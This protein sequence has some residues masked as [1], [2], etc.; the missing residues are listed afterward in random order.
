MPR[1]IAVCPAL[2][3]C[4]VAS[5]PAQEAPPVACDFA[6]DIYDAPGFRKDGGDFL[7]L[8]ECLD[9]SGGGAVGWEAERSD[10]SL[11]DPGGGVRADEDGTKFAA[12]YRMLAY[13]CV[14][15]Q[16]ADVSLWARVRQPDKPNCLYAGGH[17]WSSEREYTDA[18]L[19]PQAE[20][21]KWAGQWRWARLRGMRLLQGM[22][23]IRLVYS[24][25][26]SPEID[27]L[28]VTPDGTTPE[29]PGP[30]ER[31]AAPSG[32]RLESQDV[33]LP[34]L[35]RL[36]S[37]EVLGDLR[38][39]ALEASIDEGQ[40]WQPARD[41][42]TPGRLRLRLTFPRGA[43][44]LG[45]ASGFC[46]QALVDPSQYLMLQSSG[47]RLGLDTTT[48]GVFRLTKTGSGTVS[49]G[50]G[51]ETVPD[52]VFVA[53][54]A[55]EPLFALELKQRGKPWPD[56]RYWLYPKD[57]RLVSAR[58]LSD[59]QA[60]IACSFLDG[61]LVATATVSV[62][63]GDE[64][65]WSLRI[66]NASEWD[67]LTFSFP[68]LAGLKIGDSGY[69]DRWLNTNR[70]G[71]WMAGFPP[72]DRPYP[73]WGALGF[74]DL[75]DESA[76]LSFATREP[77]DG[78]TNFLLRSMERLSGETCRLE[79]Q[80]EHCV[81]AGETRTWTY[82]VRL[83]AGDWHAAADAYGDWFRREFGEADFPD[84]A[85]DSNGWVQ[86]SCAL[87]DASYQWPQLLGLYETGRRMGITH[88][89]VWGQFGSNTCAS[90]WWPSP[91][92]GSAEEF[93]DANRRIREQGGH[94]GYY[95]LY[96]RENRYNVIDTAT[97]DGYLPRR[98]YP[99]DMP[100]VTPEALIQGAMVSD[101][102]GKVT[103]WPA[104]DAEMSAF[105]A[106][107]AKL[108]AEGKMTTWADTE[109]WPRHSMAVM[110]PQ[111]EGWQRWLEL[112]AIDYYVKRWHC[113]TAYEDVL[114]CGNPGRSFDLRRGDHGQV[115]NTEMALAQRL[116]E[117]GRRADPDFTLIAEGKQELVTRWAMGMASSQHYGWIDHA[118]HRYTHPD[119]ILFL[120]GSN[121]GYQQMYAN[122][123]RAY[124]FG[125]RFDLILTGD[126]YDIR[127]IVTFREGLKR[128]FTRAR[129]RDTVGLRVE[130]EG[131]EATRHDRLDAG[132]QSI[133]ATVVNRSGATDGVLAIDPTALGSATYGA[134]WLQDDW[135]V[136]PAALTSRQGWVSTTIPP[137]PASALLLVARAPEGEDLLG[138]LLPER[139]PNGWRARVWLANLTPS[140]RTVQ[141]TLQGPGLPTAP[142][143]VALPGNGVRNRFVEMDEGSRTETV[144]DPVF[145]DVTLLAEGKPLARNFLYPLLE[146]GSFEQDGTPLADAPDGE[147]A[148]H[149]GPAEGWQ[150]TY[151]LLNLVPG[152]RYQ[153]GVT[154]RRTGTQG[155]MYGLVRMRDGEQWHYASLNFPEQ[156]LN[157][158]VDLT[159]DFEA[160]PT[161]R[162]ANLY[163]YNSKSEATV[164]YDRLWV[165]MVE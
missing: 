164:D 25:P 135:T 59:S 23:T 75:Y 21:A 105:K 1:P 99:P 98:L 27:R 73:G 38:G 68:R 127:R 24:W 151:R 155:E 81:A 43:T 117:A 33:T 60:E 133:L 80:K 139:T 163:L 71:P 152:R 53:P 34:A 72:E 154:A 61:K 20:H 123:E 67:V 107:L 146:D 157:E 41:L 110:N 58:K 102:E 148:V 50:G 103:A 113:D 160:P 124:L 104:T 121:G 131:I 144:P 29:G 86:T 64:G 74:V 118:A 92:Y 79:A 100:Q 97:V 85:R 116:A 14:S 45:R 52:P 93:A 132:A 88:A 28:A 119:H 56:P 87:S 36:V 30:G 153:A 19:D 158:W 17:Q 57:G 156:P 42:D 46:V 89:Q 84:W 9:L 126:V 138:G 111:D 150:G 136:Q 96:D 159:V 137:N 8:T 51:G 114:G 62:G 69:D 109:T 13:A 16:A 44:P 76:G 49:V 3:A 70:Y 5:V 22:Q 134:F 162:E 6:V 142:E 65:E 120:G 115:Y 18:G 77:V 128:F 10:E 4:L 32:Y 63:D 40:S 129:Y 35:R 130:G 47:T 11:W 37:A 147:R 7:R 15:D 55:A 39:G 83:H 94:I 149:F 54:P 48:P 31:R 95:F 66:E 141:V 122:C 2:V 140:A 143:P 82:A 26:G 78:T 165:R 106:G 108:L 90:V 145:G 12:G 125:S 161:L 112:A 91:K 101:P